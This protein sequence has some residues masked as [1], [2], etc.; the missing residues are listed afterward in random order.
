MDHPQLP[1]VPPP[2]SAGV[3]KNERDLAM[4]CHLI[5]LIAGVIGLGIIGFL[6]P[7]LIMNSESQRSSY[8][9]HHAKDSLNF[10]LSILIYSAVGVI[11]AFATCGLG[12]L[13]LIPLLIVFFIFEIIA[14]VAAT[15]GELYL[16]PLTIHFV[17]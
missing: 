2:Q 15:K 10:Q 14:T 6:G 5:P 17:K 7:L 3:P 16:Y 12:I 9:I 8:V 13:L 1:A 11:I 4:W